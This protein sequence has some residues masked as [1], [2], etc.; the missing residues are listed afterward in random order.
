MRDTVVGAAETA[1]GRPCPLPDVAGPGRAE[2]RP[3]AEGRPVS[4][5]GRHGSADAL[6]VL[7]YC[8]EEYFFGEGSWGRFGRDDDVCEI[9][10]WNEIRDVSLSR[11]A[12][13][14][15]CADGQLWVRNLSASH[16]LV[17][18][19]G[20]RPQWLGRREPGSRGAA[21]SVPADG[22]VITAPS[23]G[24]W[25]LTASSLC[26]DR[27]AADLTAQGAAA[28]DRL[29]TVR[30]EPVPERY[31]AVASALCA[32]LLADSDVPATYDE[33]ARRL[34]ISRRQARRY[35]EQLCD[36][37]RVA[38]PEKV[39]PPPSPGVPAYQPLARL[40]VARGLVRE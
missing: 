19:G 5:D 13:E 39:L 28:A 22:A 31:A 12:G 25:R 16:E 11:V 24:T 30:V 37:Y 27:A 35:I 14:I 7:T 20:G 8:D 36:Y 29:T 38:L 3:P 6:F 17:V 40:L 4:A 10:V 33:V 2:L 26:A 34:G 23:T 15:W 9:T 32:P 21:C 1:K 18:R